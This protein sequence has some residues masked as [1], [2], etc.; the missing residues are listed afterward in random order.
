MTD[1]RTNAR[2]TA[3]LLYYDLTLTAFVS[4]EL[5]IFLKKKKKCQSGSEPAMIGSREVLANG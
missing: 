4:G 2:T 3:R 5:K 1:R